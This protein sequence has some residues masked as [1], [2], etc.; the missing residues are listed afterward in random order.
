MKEGL[1]KSSRLCKNSYLLFR[2]PE[3][4][5]TQRDQAWSC[6]RT[7][8]WQH[9]ETF[10]THTHTPATLSSS[11]TGIFVASFVPS[12][13]GGMATSSRQLVKRGRTYKPSPLHSKQPSTCGCCRSGNLELF[14]H[15]IFYFS[16]FLFLVRSNTLKSNY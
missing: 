7:H 16:P 12:Q 3:G 15:H 5:C 2:H 14:L 13:V 4:K 6:T 8:P 10:Q 11:T 9:K 1:I